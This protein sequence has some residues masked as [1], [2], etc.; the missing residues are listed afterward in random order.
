MKPEIVVAG[1][2]CVDIIPALCGSFPDRPGTLVEVGP[3]TV[4]TGGVVGNTGLALHLIGIP[5]A[6]MGK[7]GDDSLGRTLRNVIDSYGTHLSR[8]MIVSP[9]ESSS[10]TLVISPPDTDRSF[11]HYPGPNNTFGSSD[12]PYDDVAQ[13]RLFHFGYPF[14]MR[15]FYDENEA[16][17]STMYQ[18]VKEVGL[19]TSLDTGIFDPKVVGHV[20]ARRLLQ[21]VLPWV[22]I[23]MP[24][25][26]ELQ[27][28]LDRCGYDNGAELGTDTIVRLAEESIQIGAKV[29][30]VK[31][32]ERGLYIRT[33]DLGRF[34]DFG[35]ARPREVEQWANRELWSPC[36]TPAVFSGTTG[37]GDATIAGFL[38]SILRGCSLTETAAFA[39]AVGACCVEAPNAIGG[40]RSWDSTWERLNKGWRRTEFCPGGDGWVHDVSSGLWIGPRD[41]GRD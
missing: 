33:A 26:D 30:G 40:I 32:G 10:Y 4:S 16:E 38:A 12:I 17:L 29:V 3:A 31:C 21:G 6:L 14:L 11:L 28:T 7:I 20:D 15:R 22:D 25:A 36:F 1:H 19:S 5:T 35:K 39:C 13:A 41:C 2:I 37:T 23:F 34:D 27:F 9:D 8:Y 24:S 18:R